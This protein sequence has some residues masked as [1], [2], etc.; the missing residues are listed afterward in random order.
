M[1]EKVS[2]MA[3]V[4]GNKN[5]ILILNN[6]GE[7]VFPKGHV[8]NNETY[9]Q[10]SIRELKEETNVSV[11]EDDCLGQIDEFKFYFDKEK[12]IKVI[13]V[14]LFKIDSLPLITVNKEER[15]ISGD[16]VLI[17]DAIRKLSHDDARGSLEK[18]I[19][20]LNEILK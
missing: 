6:E 10:A 7:W 15:F 12:A 13:K 4:I 1:K 19:V 18:A 9:L 11:C 2:S 20:K 3:I 16:W 14:F 8:E 5:K 17:E